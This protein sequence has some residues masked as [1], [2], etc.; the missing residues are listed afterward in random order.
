[1]TKTIEKL[2]HYTHCGLDNI[3]LINGFTWH[4][5]E[6]YGEGVSFHNVDDLHAAI[7]RAIVH[8]DHVLSGKEFRYLRHEMEMTQADVARLFGCDTQTVARWE[9]SQTALPI[10]DDRLL[11]FIY[12]QFINEDENVIGLLEKLAELDI[13]KNK[14]L[15]FKETSKGWRL[16]A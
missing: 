6:G 16:A 12:L 13:E 10:A 2:Y 15:K 3:Y 5:V 1:M 9:K 7:G 8:F 4:D 14:K 11:R